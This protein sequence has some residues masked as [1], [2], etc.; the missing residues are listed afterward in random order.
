[1]G[2]IEESRFYSFR[3]NHHI[4]M[5]EKKQKRNQKQLSSILDHMDDVVWSASWPEM[6]LIYVS[7]SVEK[8][9]GRPRQDFLDHKNLWFEVVD[10]ADKPRVK[11]A[12]SRLA[13]TG[14]N[15]LQYRIVRPDKRIVWL[16]D[17]N[18]LVADSSGK[19]VSVDGIASD[20][21]AQKKAEQALR[22]SEQRSRSIVE[23]IPD[24]M[25]VT[26]REGVYL[27]IITS[28]PDKLA[29]PKQMVLGKKVSDIL[30]PA[31]SAMVMQAIRKSLDT[32]NLQVAEYQLD[33]PA[34]KLFFE[35]RIIRTGDDKAM[36]LI[37]DITS[38][39]QTEQR[40]KESRARYKSIADNSPVGGVPIHPGHFRGSKV[41]LYQL[42][43]DPAYRPGSKGH[44][45]RPHPDPGPHTPQPPQPR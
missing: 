35:A 36:A 21:T 12:M 24:M 41:Y 31:E 2:T 45:W 43:N 30:P 39:K 7:P 1:M 42:E 4:A 16:E 29:V 44:L 26:N 20:I 8:I 9:F 11:K 14:K 38:G 23:V 27:D 15:K 22:Q 13:H 19:T 40:L 25:V 33:V 17:K 37:R 28:S 5:I 10:D 6:A 18:W 32:G 34:G 3:G